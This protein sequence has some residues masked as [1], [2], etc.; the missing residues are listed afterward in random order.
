MFYSKIV[1]TLTSCCITFHDVTKLSS[2][3]L[4][5]DHTVSAVNFVFIDKYFNMPSFFK[6]QASL[7]NMFQLESEIT[8][9]CFL[10][11][12]VD[13]DFTSLAQCLASYF[14]DPQKFS[15]FFSIVFQTSTGKNLWEK[16]WKIFTG[17]G[18]LMPHILLLSRIVSFFLSLKHQVKLVFSVILTVCVCLPPQKPMSLQNVA[19]H[20]KG[21]CCLASKLCLME[22][23]MERSVVWKQ[24]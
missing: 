11:N 8:C 12:S 23:K 5:P 18:N 14:L 21:L 4:F 19:T 3:Q 22:Q 6:K 9:S 17:F 7:S 24:I 16:V 15:I 1:I 2:T 20:T 10:N 13:I